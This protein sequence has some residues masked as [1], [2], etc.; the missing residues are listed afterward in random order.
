MFNNWTPWHFLIDDLRLIIYIP[1]AY[2]YIL[3]FWTFL[4]WKTVFVRPNTLYWK[5]KNNLLLSCFSP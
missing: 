1:I 4:L 2:F 5:N 3:S